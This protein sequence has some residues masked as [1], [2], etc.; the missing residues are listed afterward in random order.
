MSDRCIA[1]FVDT[2]RCIDCK[3][4]EI[5]CKEVTSAG[6]GMRIRRVRSFESGMF[7][8][9]RVVNI[10]MSCNHCEDPLCARCCPAKAYHKRADGIVMHDQSRCIGCR[11]CTW[12]CPYGSP[13][14]DEVNGC[15]RKCDLCAET[16]GTEKLPACVEACPTRAISVQW[17]DP[18]SEEREGTMEIPSL[19]APTITKPSTRYKVRGEGRN[20]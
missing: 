15:I 8:H 20:G 5:A 1:F 3:T 6:P 14:Y 17:L 12:V 13:Q 16:V 7:P 4:C 10:S 19:P 2:T 11:Y 9:V 18:S